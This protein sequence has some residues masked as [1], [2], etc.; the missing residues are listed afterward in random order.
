[1]SICPWQRNALTPDFAA[2]KVPIMDGRHLLSE[3]LARGVRQAQLARDAKCSEGHL[4]LYLKGKRGMS[5]SLAKRIS[6]A[7]GI[8]AKSLVPEKAAEWEGAE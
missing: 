4:S 3:F 5:V 7:T 6:A 8:P 1:M 2:G